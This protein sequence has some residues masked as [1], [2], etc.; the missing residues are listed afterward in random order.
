MKGKTLCFS[1]HRP[2]KLPM[3]GDAATAQMKRLISLL[4]LEIEKSVQSGYN[5]FITGMAK[6]IDL[7]AAKAVIELRDTH[8]EIRLVCAVPYKGYGNNWKGVDKWDL[9][10]ILEAS[11]EIVYICDEYEKAC[12]RKRNEYMVDRSSKLIAVLDDYKSG[13]GQTVRY[14]QKHGLDVRIINPKSA[15]CPYY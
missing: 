8:P 1:G 6:G 11:D 15:L 13:T 7:W 14:A 2:E 12:M 3:L 9:G 10:L 4:F 5:T